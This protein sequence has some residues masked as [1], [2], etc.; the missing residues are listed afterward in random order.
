MVKLV[1]LV[2]RRADLTQEEFAR[3]WREEHAPLA[4]RQGMR[5]YV[6][7]VALRPQ[8]GGAAPR[9]DGV[10]EIWWDDVASMEAALASPAGVAAAADVARF[11]A[12]VEFLLCAEHEVALGVEGRVA[13][14]A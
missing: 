1:A 14:P 2:R 13:P 4:A 6:I 11:A 3:Y 8:P 10:A 7:D 5:R 9:Y 12:S